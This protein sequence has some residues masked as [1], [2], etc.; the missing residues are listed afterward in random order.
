MILQNALGIHEDS[1]GAIV[2]REIV[3]IAL[4]PMQIVAV[5][6]ILLDAHGG[7][8]VGIVSKAGGIDRE[9]VKQKAVAFLGVHVEAAAKQTQAV[10]VV[11]VVAIHVHIAA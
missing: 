4:P 7:H 3:V 8:C 6:I 2:E 5:D 10:A 11:H 9:V 1:A